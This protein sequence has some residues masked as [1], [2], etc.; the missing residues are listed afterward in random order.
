MALFNKEAEKNP[1]P[2]PTKPQVT[3]LQAVTPPGA[4][5]D[6]LLPRAATPSAPMT[7]ASDGRAYL[8]KGC[9][10]SGKLFFEGPVKID[11]Q[12]DGQIDANDSVFI[13]DS[14]VVTA[15]IKAASVAVAGK[16]SGDII[17]TK[18]VE[19]RPSAKVLGNLTTPV[20]VVHE[21]AVFE[22]HCAM[23]AEHSREEHKITLFPKE[24][25]RIANSGGQ[26]PA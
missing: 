3:P 18:R 11:G 14:A 24:E 26:K 2:Q 13:G 20:L 15:Q 9:K 19:I 22:G 23:Q 25:Q 7:A 17:A 1:K 6:E 5:H 8:D 21:G 12:V 16:V 10:I 4:S